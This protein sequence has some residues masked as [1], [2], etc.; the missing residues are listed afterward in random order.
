[1]LRLQR[2]L[3]QLRVLIDTRRF[4]RDLD[5]ELRFHAD[6]L[7]ANGGDTADARRRLPSPL[8]TREESRDAWGVG[9][10]DRLV[11]D[12]RYALRLMLRRPGFSATA[13]GVL[14]LALGASIT[15]FSVV[16]AVL[17]RSL[18]FPESDRLVLIA[19]GLPK[20]A[21]LEIL[22]V[23]PPDIGA[24][25]EAQRSF[26]SL[27][28]FHSERYEVSGI[29]EAERVD[30]ARAAP[31]L[32]ATLGV[33]P[34]LG[35]A[36]TN[37]EDRGA[38]PVAIISHG[39]W[40]RK[41]QSDPHVLGKVIHLER[42]P[43]TIVAVLPERFEF[44]LRGTGF[45][46]HPADV[47][48]PLS[49]TKDELQGYGMRFKFFM[50][51]RLNPGV[52]IA[53]AR[54][55]SDGLARTLLE[56]YPAALRQSD[57]RFTIGFPMLPLHAAV[58]GKVQTMLWVLL[59]AVLLVL[60]VGCADLGGLLL[61][62]AAARAG[63][64]KVRAA[65]GAGRGR[66]VRQ[67]VTESLVIAAIGGACGLALAYWLTTLIS[68]AFADSLPRAH[69][70]ALDRN[71]VLASIGLTFLAALACGLAPAIWITDARSL[72][73]S[74]RESSGGRGERR[75]VQTLVIVQVTLA[76]VLAIGAGLLAR[77][78]NHLLAIDPGY[79]SE[80]VV[81]V[82]VSLPLG[83]YSRPAEIRGFFQRAQQV[84]DQL[85]GAT[86]TALTGTLPMSFFDQRSFTAEH[87]P[88][89]VSE[90]AVAMSSVAGAYFA[91]LGIPL[92]DGRFFVRDEQPRFIVVNETLARMMWPGKSAV[93][94]RLKWG[95]GPG[96][97]NPYMT[98]V[99]VVGDVK[100]RGLTAPAQPE[101][102]A[103]YSQSGDDSLLEPGWDGYRTMALLV[104]S[105][106]NVD[107]NVMLG[108][109]R[110]R[111]QKLDPSL[112]ITNAKQLDTIVADA[113]APQRFN[114]WLLSAFAIASVALAALGLYGL[115]ASVVVSRTREIG[116]RVALGARRPDVLRLIVGQGVRL[117]IVGLVLGLAGAAF[118][119]RFMQTLLFGVRP[120][121]PIT[122][123]VVSMVLVVV[124]LL[125]ALVPA[126]RAATIDPVRALRSE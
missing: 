32:F 97:N 103:P 105:N 112:A 11:Q 64:L 107:P 45:N 100:Q 33:Q 80:H 75:L 34:M 99:G 115:L 56:R 108:M 59:A 46:D 61:T 63:E 68:V 4:S 119:T 104:R 19:E 21:G 17:M 44:P 36:F 30:A 25:G 82:T 65:L 12:V 15:V 89:G 81:T 5:E 88:A 37:E 96:N 113:V 28:A 90:P 58:V 86:S 71:I 49:L 67:L 122:F 8:R 117:V 40:Q 48:V 62:R 29:G 23:S 22:G 39:L 20:I 3:R 60:L 77:S 121:D 83:G 102:Y 9:W 51:G 10:W 38:A 24:F 7:D 87:R 101:I 84:L 125:A 43:Y 74:A 18:P 55:E 94:E 106:A 116:V 69:E 118:L 126:W 76:L 120:L 98:I 31:G 123:T 124:G 42:R 95:S 27:A 72:A 53:A 109:V 47:F 79:R 114:A 16:Y 70:I 66:L 50:V 41:F 2:L 78:L 91:T 13:I 14:A 110:Q 111:I 35:R 85:P 6:M 73:I 54:A 1:M 92:R 57:A 26:S 93:G 52:D